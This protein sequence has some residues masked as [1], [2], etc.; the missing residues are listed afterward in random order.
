MMAAAMAMAMA[1][2]ME[3]TAATAMLV[4]ATMATATAGMEAKEEAAGL[5]GTPAIQATTAIAETMAIREIAETAVMPGVPET[6]QAATA[7]ATATA[8]VPVMREPVKAG[9]QD[10]KAPRTLEARQ[11][12]AIHP[13]KGMHP[14]TAALRAPRHLEGCRAF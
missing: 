8:E 13:L 7:T 4:T 2:A 3:A 9:P 14:E 11:A 5:Q 12:E 6:P 1:M 10:R